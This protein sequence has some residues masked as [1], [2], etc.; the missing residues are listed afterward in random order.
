MDPEC[1]FC[2]IVKGEI[3]CYKVYEDK[4]NLAFLDVNPVAKGH[5]LVIPK[6]H[7]D[8]LTGI[9]E[10]ESYARALGTVCLKVEAGLSKHYNLF[11]AQGSK[12]WQT[13]FHHHMHVIP[14]YGGEKH[15]DWPSGKLSPAEAQELVKRMSD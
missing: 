5:T 2:K 11:G 4:D 9:K 14:R 3:P 10:L 1:I 7:T 12:A 15:W 13:V 6:Q 8:R